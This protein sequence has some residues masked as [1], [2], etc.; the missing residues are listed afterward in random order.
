MR[1]ITIGG[2]NVPLFFSLWEMKQIQEEV[3]FINE[4]NEK[5]AKHVGSSEQIETLVK[6]IRI[7]GNAGLEEAGQAADLTDKWV[8]RRLTIGSILAMTEDIILCIND[9]MQME[10][11]IAEAEEPDKAKDLGLEELRRK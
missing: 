8:G 10:N 2:R 7:L 5:L 4:I 11:D 3:G 6:L 9:G 1:F